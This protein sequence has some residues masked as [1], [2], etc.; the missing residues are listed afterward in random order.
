MA[1]PI[2]TARRLIETYAPLSSD[3]TTALAAIDRM[4]P[5]AQHDERDCRDC[6]EAFYLTEPQREYFRARGLQEPARC[7]ACRDARRAALQAQGRA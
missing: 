7:K 4:L 3:R 2:E 1:H 5:Y 6:G